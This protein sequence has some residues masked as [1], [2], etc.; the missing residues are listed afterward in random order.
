MLNL[1]Q[2]AHFS[3]RDLSARKA[4]LEEIAVLSGFEHIRNIL[5]ELDAMAIINRSADMARNGSLGNAAILQDLCVLCLLS[6]S[7]FDRRYSPA[8]P[9]LMERYYLGPRATMWRLISLA[10]CQHAATS[11]C[12]INLGTHRTLQ[13]STIHV[14]YNSCPECGDDLTN[15]W[16]PSSGIYRKLL[17][18]LVKIIR[19]GYSRHCSNAD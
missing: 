10:N 1:M 5:N 3:H 4:A 18:K 13:E 8:D 12:Q 2:A 14:S 17:A 15:G 16:D 7:N 6:L 9:E 11:D 19:F